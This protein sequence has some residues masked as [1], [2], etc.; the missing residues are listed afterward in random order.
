M[1]E[2]TGEE[3]GKLGWTDFRFPIPWTSTREPFQFP[4]HD[5]DDF[6]TNC[7]NNFIQLLL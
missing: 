6:E 3:I 1:K 5:E 4:L 2:I 7:H